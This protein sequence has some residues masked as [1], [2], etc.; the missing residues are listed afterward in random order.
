MPPTP[1]CVTCPYTTLFRSRRHQ[2]RR[3]W[4]VRPR[5]QARSALRRRDRAT[6]GGLR[7][8]RF[9]LDLRALGL[10]HSQGALR[11]RQPE[12]SE[13]HTPELQSHSELVCRLLP[14][15]KNLHMMLLQALLE[16]LPP[17]LLD[18]V[19]VDTALFGSMV[20]L[21][22]ALN[23]YIVTAVAA[24]AVAVTAHT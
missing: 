15:K 21:T 5:L 3:L 23:R 4:R 22:R 19:I 16:P 11:M 2:R 13:E 18:P 24:E 1:S 8:R 17:E 10:P 14:E 12:R 7:R 20:V 9:H 6:A